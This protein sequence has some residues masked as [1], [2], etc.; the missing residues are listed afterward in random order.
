M[1]TKQPAVDMIPKFRTIN[2]G[3]VR[4]TECR[5]TQRPLAWEHTRFG[6]TPQPMQLRNRGCGVRGRGGTAARA[7]RTGWATSCQWQHWVIPLTLPLW[8]L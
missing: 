6:T 8:D 2:C 5:T 4:R 3:L 7:Q 1:W